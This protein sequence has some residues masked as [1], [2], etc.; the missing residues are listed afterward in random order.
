MMMMFKPQLARAAVRPAQR[1]RRTFIDWMV[2]Y[3]DTVSEE[4]RKRRK[5][6]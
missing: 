2:N 3:P 1:Q 5:D 4:T 6:E